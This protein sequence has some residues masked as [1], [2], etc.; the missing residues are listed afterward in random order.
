[1]HIYAV[2]SPY[3]TWVHISMTCLLRKE[4]TQGG[5]HPVLKTGSRKPSA[6][7]DG[8][9]S[10]VCTHRIVGD[11]VGAGRYIQRPIVKP[12]VC[13]L[14]GMSGLLLR[15]PFFLEATSTI[16]RHLLLPFSVCTIT[17][18]QTNRSCY[19]VVCTRFYRH[20]TQPNSQEELSSYRPCP[21]RPTHRNESSKWHKGK[22][23][24]HYQTAQHCTTK[25]TNHLQKSR[26][27]VTPAVRE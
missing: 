17:W 9:G 11:P 6:H 22:M 3:F 13:T 16:Q 14:D 1:M 21:Q 10:Y 19:S 18:T 5:G 25:P 27:F 24:P 23:Q 20:P 12:G 15:C 26:G 2:M 7:V 4:C 8:I